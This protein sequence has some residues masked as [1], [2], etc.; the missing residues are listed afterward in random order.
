MP[1]PENVTNNKIQPG[2]TRNPNGRPIGTRNRSTIITEILEAIHDGK[3]LDGTE[4]KKEIEYWVTLKKVKNAL[5]GRD[6]AINDVLDWKYGKQ[7]EKKEINAKVS[8]IDE[9]V[10]EMTNK[11]EAPIEKQA[12]KIAETL[13]ETAQIAAT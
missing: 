13:I 11:Y 5:A 4:T 7:I 2:E 9:L 12:E 8:T 3:E 6:T 1:N 10:N